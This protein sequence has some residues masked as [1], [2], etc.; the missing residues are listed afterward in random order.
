MCEGA[1]QN[2]MSGLLLATGLIDESPKV[3]GLGSAVYDGAVRFCPICDGFE[4][5][6]RRIGVLGSADE[7]GRKALFLRT[8]S[9]H[10]ML[11]EKEKNSEA[12]RETLS[13]GRTQSTDT[14]AAQGR[15]RGAATRAGP[16]V[17]NPT[18]V[19]PGECDRPKRG[20]FP[21]S[22]ARASSHPLAPV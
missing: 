10:V 4:A 1:P 9:R 5:M 17:R 6:D 11:F 16:S 8:Y 12:M 20:R 21:K 22:H 18:L 7:A 3:E 19:S 14:A 2:F 13:H 15:A